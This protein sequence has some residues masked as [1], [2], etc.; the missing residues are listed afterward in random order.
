[1]RKIEQKLLESFKK[2]NNFNSGIDR[3]EVDALVPK[4]IN[5]YNYD[6]FVY[7]E[8]TKEYNEK[9]ISFRLPSFDG[10]LSNTTKS[11][12]NAFLMEYDL[13][14][15]QKTINYSVIIK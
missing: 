11:R 4:S 14:I 1:M 9:I 7:S 6:C 3:I 12:I 5:Y 15:K 8:Q 10:G 13:Q 2:R